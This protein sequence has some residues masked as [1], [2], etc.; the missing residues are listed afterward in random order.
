MIR[1]AEKNSV[2]LISVSFLVGIFLTIMPLPQWAIWLRPQ[3][4]FAIL[5]FW[6]I[7]SPMQCGIGVGF[8]VGLLVDLVTGTPI[9]EHALVFVVLTYIVLKLHRAIVHFPIVQQAG[10]VAIFTPSGPRVPRRGPSALGHGQL[11]HAHPC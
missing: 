4:M 11:W 8:F 10:M 7:R 2:F 6:V 5:L 1:R 9:G 3:W